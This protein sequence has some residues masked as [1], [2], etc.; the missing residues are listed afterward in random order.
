MIKIFKLEIIKAWLTIIMTVFGGAGR[1]PLILEV[2]LCSL[3][4]FSGGAWSVLTG[5]QIGCLP[6][7]GLAA[8]YKNI[9]INFWRWFKFSFFP[10]FKLAGGRG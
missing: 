10:C 6:T 8:A 2:N 3:V 1:V 7:S 5:C 9:K 4:L